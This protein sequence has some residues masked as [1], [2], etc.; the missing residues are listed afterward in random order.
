MAVVIEFS[1]E[2]FKRNTG[3][4]FAAGIFERDSGKL[5]M[6]GINRVV[7]LS[8]SSAHAE[9]MAISLAQ[10]NLGVLDLGGPGMP[11]YQIVVNWL[12]CAMCFGA[13]LWSG[14]RSLVI[15]GDGPELEAITGFDEG[16]IHP[17]WRAEL[18]KRDIGL[19]EDILRADAIAAYREY[20]ATN[21]YVY[22]ARLGKG[23]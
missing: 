16:P 11:A 5:V 21:P 13:V 18:A 15:A 10:R 3:G 19:H 14:V 7:P 4:P 2:N 8:C 23:E 20:A 12:P 17:Q 22:N 9:I 1:R 6:I